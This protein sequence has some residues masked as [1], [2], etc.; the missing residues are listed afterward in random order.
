[1][2]NY[3]QLLDEAIKIKKEKELTFRDLELII[4]VSYSQL[5]KVFTRMT[6]KPNYIVLIKFFKAFG[7]EDLLFETYAIFDYI[8]KQTGV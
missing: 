8:T 3:E 2:R 4:G 1:M 7:R 5:C 6:K